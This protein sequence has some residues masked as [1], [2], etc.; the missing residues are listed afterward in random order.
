MNEKG[1]GAVEEE[2]MAVVE[3]KVSWA[4]WAVLFPV[5]LAE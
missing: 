5:V 3:A 1:W 2:A 4:A